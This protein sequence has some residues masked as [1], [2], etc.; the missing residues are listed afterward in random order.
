MIPD[1]GQLSR[2]AEPSGAEET[3]WWL[4]DDSWDV[5]LDD[6][7]TAFADKLVGGVGGVGGTRKVG[8]DA[9]ASKEK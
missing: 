7:S 3:P 2:D 9:G 1:S 4:E 6:M 8:T 5:E